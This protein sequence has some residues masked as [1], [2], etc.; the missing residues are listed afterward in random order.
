MADPEVRI[1]GFEAVD[2]ALQDVSMAGGDD[3]EIVEIEDGANGDGAGT[4][5][6]GLE[7]TAARTTFIEYLMYLRLS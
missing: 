2:E 6:A 5:D 3:A 4:D 1:E 7:E